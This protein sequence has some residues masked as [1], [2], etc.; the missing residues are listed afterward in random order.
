MS[1]RQHCVEYLCDVPSVYF[2]SCRGF[3]INHTVIYSKTGWEASAFVVSS[4][5][6]MNFSCPAVPY[7]S[8]ILLYKTNCSLC[9]GKEQKHNL[10][11]SGE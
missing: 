2:V 5:L 4:E 10:L 7:L 3:R 6:L 1:L 8:F 11:I 9:L